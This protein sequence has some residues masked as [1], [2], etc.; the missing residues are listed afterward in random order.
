LLGH[1]P[2]KDGA[3]NLTL[4]P[5]VDGLNEP[6]AGVVAERHDAHLDA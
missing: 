3:V 1:R 5:V 4:G 6:L 2:G